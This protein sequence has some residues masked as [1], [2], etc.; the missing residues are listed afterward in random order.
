MNWKK[1]LLICAIILVVGILITAFIFLTEPTAK[2]TGATKETA[3]LVEVTKVRKGNF[4]P[5]ISATGTVQPDQDIILSPRVS[6]QVLDLSNSFTP[7]GYVKKGEILLQVDPA[8][9]KN[10]LERAESDL[11]QA[12]TELNVELGRQEVAKKDY[13][14]LEETLSDEDKALVLREP[15]LD[16][17]RARVESAQASVNQA[18][19]NL[20]RTTIKAPFDALI[21]TRNANVGSQVSPG[22][23][24]GRMVGIDHYWVITSVPMS[25][26]KW[27]SFPENQK[28]KGSE[29]KIKNRTAWSENQFRTGSLHKLVGALDEQTR[30]ARV[31]VNVEDPLAQQIDSAGVPKLMIGEFVEVQIEGK[32]I[33]N[34]IRLN[35]DY[36]RKNDKVWVMKDGRLKIRDVKILLKDSKYAYIEKG[37]SDDEQVVITNLSTV[38]DGARLRV[39]ESSEKHLSDSLKNVMNFNSNEIQNQFVGELR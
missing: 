34:V 10:I 9:Y 3:M 37:L 38:T 5:I 12:M 11:R 33:S 35:R 7:G 19:L 24:L 28:E 39:N 14:L 36:L 6:G 29:V 18:K 4:H 26:I 25:K 22:E 23:N 16:A 20:N 30:L 8:D 31:I 1:T 15:Q 27:L 21:L 2:R 13:E 17:V 32:E